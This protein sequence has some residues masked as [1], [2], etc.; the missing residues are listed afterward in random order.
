MSIRLM[1]P[2]NASSY[3]AEIVHLDKSTLLN[4][5]QS[6]KVPLPI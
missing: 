2:L 4:E 1:Q 6:A 5:I 3:N